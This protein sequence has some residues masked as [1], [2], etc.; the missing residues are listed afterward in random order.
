MARTN[1]SF[2]GPGIGLGLGLEF[3]TDG[4]FD[5]NKLIAGA[6]VTPLGWGAAGLGRFTHH[7]MVDGRMQPLGLRW[8]P[9]IGAGFGQGSAS[10]FYAPTMPEN[11][12]NFFRAH[13]R[14][15]AALRLPLGR[16]MVEGAVEGT[17]WYLGGMNGGING[18]NYLEASLSAEI[19]SGWS[20]TLTAEEG[21]R[22]PQFEKTARAAVG[23]GFRLPRA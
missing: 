17:S 23:L 3:E 6:E 9:W 15:E 22:P 1:W 11:R 18:T 4:N 2:P 14:V 8:R 19:G 20:L 5:L 12:S 7:R 16:V 21:R 10:G 13:A